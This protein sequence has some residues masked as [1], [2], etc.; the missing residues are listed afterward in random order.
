MNMR[1]ASLTVLFF[2]LASWFGFPVEGGTAAGPN[3]LAGGMS[4]QVRGNAA[5]PSP[6][7]DYDGLTDD[8]E[9][10]G[11][12]DAAG[13]FST[14]PHDPD[15]D[16]DGLTDGEEKLYDTDPLDDHSPGIYVEYEARL[17][18]RQYS[19]KVSY[20]QPWGWQ[21]Y[22]DQLISLDAVVVRRGSTFSVGGPANA[23][24]QVNKSLSSL[25]TLT[26]VRDACNGRWRI[27]VPAGGTVGRYEIVLRDGEWS[28]KLKLYVIFELPAPTSSFTQAM[29]DTFLYD[30]DPEN[31]RDEVGIQL[32]DWRYTHE[33][34]PSRIP[35]GAWI[36]A[37]SVYRFQLEQF[38]PFVFEEHV[39]Q[40]IN[41]Q[42]DQ[43]SAAYALV[44]RADKV[45][46]FNYPRVLHS[47][48]SVLH[49]GADDSNQCSNIA[50]LLTAFLR[51]AGIPARPFFVD[52]AYNTFDHAAEIWLYG[53][54]VAARGY[55]RVEP[56]G[57]GWNCGYGYLSPRS[58]YSWGRDIYRP[59]HS[60]GGGSGSTVMAADENWVWWQTGWT[61]DS[62]GHDYRWPSWDWDAIVRYAWFDTLFVPYWSYWGWSHEPHV[63]GSPPYA[64]PAPTNL[65]GDVPSE[66]FSAETIDDGQAGV[67]VGGMGDYG[68][69]LDGDGYFDQL[70]IEVEVS[71][72]QAGT[73]WLQGQLGVDRRVPNLMGSGGLIAAAVVRADLAEGTNIVQLPFDGL[74]ISAA[75]EDGPYVLQYLS[76]TDVDNPG[77]DE[78]ANALLGY[79]LSLYTTA[80]YRA[81]SFQNRGAA[82]SSQIAE[83]GLDTDGDT[84]YESLIL[85]VGLN[86]FKPGTYTVQGDLYDSRERFVAR[87]TSSGTGPTAVLQFD[88]LSDAVGPYTL[89]QVSLLNA[90]GELIDSLVS[91]YTTQQVTQ[92]DRGT[93]IL[94]PGESGEVGLQGIL[95]GPYA[96]AGLDLDGDGLYDLLT[97]DVQVEVEETGQYRL[98]GWLQ[99][100]SSSLVSW[101][102]SDPISVTTVGTYT[103]SLAF[104]GPAISAHNTAGPFTLTVLKL[105]R[106]AG[107]EVVDEVDVAYTTASAYTPEQFERLPYLELPADY[108]ILFEDH[109]EDGE[110]AWTADWPWARTTTWFHSPIQAWTDSPGGNYGNGRDVSLTTSPM[111]LVRFSRPTLQFQTCYDL[112]TNYDYGRIEISTDGGVTWHSVT[113]YTGR[114][115][116]WSGQRVDLGMI[117]GAETLRVRFRLD[118]DAGVTADGWYIDDVVV[119]FDRDLDGDGIP[120]D[121]EVGDDPNNPVDSDGD[122]TPDYLDDDSDG[123]GI[124]DAGEWSEGSDDP[125]AGCIAGNPLCFN[126]DND[127]N[128]VPNYLDLDSDG[129]GIPD[130]GEWSAGPDDPL[131]GCTADA[132]LCFN[133]DN[134]DDGV[135]YYLDLDSDG[136]G[137]PDA[138]EWSAGPDDPLAGCTADAPLCF[139]N[140]NDGNGIPNYLDLDS[141]ADGIPDA[142]EWSAGPNDPLVGCTADDPL[143]FNNDND[144]DGV[145]NYL[146]LDSDGDGFPDSTEGTDDS[147]ADGKPDY[148]DF[149]FIKWLPIVLRQSLP[150]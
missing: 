60:G 69:D 132:P 125:L 145:P 26:P 122:A 96:D 120:N 44:A 114:T 46:R 13:F 39:I 74:R 29:I 124:P 73:Y 118:T 8:V 137:I 51:S 30:D 11:W 36:N 58:R 149:I 62:V 64:W 99:G 24:L 93:H 43:W 5:L 136:D 128:S 143:C 108:V 117:G 106:G 31:L 113:T 103:L 4:F 50:G 87:A 84:R 34:Y 95:P 97:I 82:L 52:W 66:Q 83:Q 32:G 15:S 130:A 55:T 127:G 80:A 91:A 19:A 115:V 38:E 119:Y 42:R 71:A 68:V 27:Y 49:P 37:G 121:V 17:K 89:K 35:S 116:H 142:G 1:V 129:D 135:P 112:E 21:Q 76:I 7:D 92:A 146:D 105:L 90:D 56:E 139:N 16:D 110:G 2:W 48:W 6:D 12:W 41:G 22:G 67:S 147:D 101:A 79:W 109:M 85:S 138:G 131:V 94:E 23:I 150:K 111:D 59:W 133:N 86:V 107:Y 148:L 45:T 104:S 54:W 63:T 47:S 18:T 14:D 78:F 65:A 126:N 123:D 53:A 28:K 102:V 70:V 88:G 75:K 98:E 9:T 25:T 144:G 61:E 141:D 3:G 57:C 33:D 40:A 134:D 20:F 77:P 81:D 140:D 10:N 100:G 72:T